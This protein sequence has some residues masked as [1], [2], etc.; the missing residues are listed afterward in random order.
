MKKLTAEVRELKRD[1]AANAYRLG[2]RLLQVR[3][4]RLYHNAG[5][6]TWR[7]Y[8][9]E[10]VGLNPAQAQKWMLVAR[11][12][13][14]ERAR[15]LGIEVLAQLSRPHRHPRP[16]GPEPGRRQDRRGHQ[17]AR[18]AQLARGGAGLPLC[19]GDPDLERRRPGAARGL[20]APARVPA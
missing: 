19:A 12:F 1:V 3:R 20:L 11:H 17:A 7:S 9:R 5:V 13:T 15:P 2:V 6:G 18:C 4:E 14:E 10:V 16:G 8:L